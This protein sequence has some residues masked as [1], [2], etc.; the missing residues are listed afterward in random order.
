MNQKESIPLKVHCYTK[1]KICGVRE[2]HIAEL[3]ISEGIDFLGINLSPVSKR[4]VSVGQALDLTKEI[5]KSR[6]RWN[7]GTE[8]VLVFYKNSPQEIFEI[9]D[10]IQPDRI[11]LIYGDPSLP[12]DWG[13]FRSKYRILPAYSVRDVLEDSRIPFPK[14]EIPILDAPSDGKG[15]GTG[16]VFP[17]E[18][19]AKVQRKYLLAGGLK[20]ENVERAIQILKPWGVD[21]ASGIEDESGNQSIQKIREFIRNTRKQTE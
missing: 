15:G 7:V 10:Q 1:V 19:V 11:Q 16:E 18:R 14:D 21:V 2:K 20:P 12:E 9:S 13:I 3:G 4:R 17:W 8:I 5:R 6:V